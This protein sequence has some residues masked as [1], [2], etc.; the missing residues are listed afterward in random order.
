MPA[1]PATLKDPGILDQ[2]VLD[3]RSLTHFP[4]Q[5]CCKV[6]VESRG[7]DS[8][9]GEQSEIDA[10]VPQLQFDVGSMEDGGTLQIACFLVGTDTSS[11]A[12]HATRVP[13][14]KKSSMWLHEQPCCCREL[15][16]VCTRIFFIVVGVVVCC[17]VWCGGLV[18]W[19]GGLVVWCCGV[20]R[21]GV[22]WFG[23]EWVGGGV[24]SL[25]GWWWFMFFFFEFFLLVLIS[26]SDMFAIFSSHF[27]GLCKY[28]LGCFCYLLSCFLFLL[29]SYF[30]FYW[31]WHRPPH[32]GAGAALSL[33][34]TEILPPPFEWWCFPPCTH[35]SGGAILLLSFWVVLHYKS[36]KTQNLDTIKKPKQKHVDII[37]NTKTK[38]NT[39]TKHHETTNHKTTSKHTEIEK[40]I[41]KT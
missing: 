16:V 37:K 15:C 6:C 26:F 11:G 40:Q 13:D 2:I 14:S 23:L 10:V 29:F 36:R 38:T 39:K 5:L 17:C 22:V 19:C 28:V 7:R 3:Q 4:N 21:C 12:I 32:L 30:P 35:W 8:P 33:F 1:R 27:P 24:L 20:W 25:F 9:H 18:V 31:L 34:W 41:T